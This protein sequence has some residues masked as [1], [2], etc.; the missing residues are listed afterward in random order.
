MESICAALHTLDFIVC[1]I[2]NILNH[3]AAEDAPIHLY[4]SGSNFTFIW[5][6]LDLYESFQNQ[7][8][9]I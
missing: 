1:H 6:N 2:P 3:I 4:Q 8:N 7:Y 9:I 5:F